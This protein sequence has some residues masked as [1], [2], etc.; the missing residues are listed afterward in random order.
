MVDKSYIYTYDKYIKTKNL[1]SE[2][3][4]RHWIYSIDNIL[5]RMIILLWLLLYLL[6]YLFKMRQDLTVKLRLVSYSCYELVNSVY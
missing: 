1:L 6:I 4:R 2:E 5:S 3:L